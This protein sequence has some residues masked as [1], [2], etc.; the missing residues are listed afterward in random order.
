MM[1]TKYFYSAFLLVFVTIASAQ[2]SVGVFGG[3]NFQ[4]MN[5]KNYSGDVLENTMIPGFN[6]GFNV[7]IPV[8]PEFYFQPGLVYST[9]GSQHQGSLQTTTTKLSYVEMPLNFVYKGLLGNG[10]VLLGV[11]PYLAYAINGKQITEAGGVTLSSP[12]QFKNVVEAGESLLI[13]YYKA[14]DAGGNIFIGYELASG[15]F[16][17]LNAQLGM[18]DINPEYKLLTN[19]KSAIKNTGFGLSLGY[20]F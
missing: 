10:Y 11:G 18:L 19:D 4:N 13:P 16:A 6:A 20:R 1:K 7:Q 17:Q 14:L 2:V 9:K 3:V 12:I 5:G 15:I 8:V